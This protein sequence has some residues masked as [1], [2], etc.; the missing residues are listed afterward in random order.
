MLYLIEDV[1]EQQHSC[2]IFAYRQNNYARI[3]YHLCKSR[4][5]ELETRKIYGFNHTGGLANEF[6]EM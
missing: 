5:H 3:V 4:L 1:F 2:A 6:I